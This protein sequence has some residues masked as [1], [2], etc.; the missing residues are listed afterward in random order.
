IITGELAERARLINELIR[1]DALISIHINAAPWPKGERRKLV[2]SDHAHVL[3]FGCMSAWEL[4]QSRQQ[5]ELIRKMI[6]GSGDIEVLLGKS[7]GHALAKGTGLV[8]SK[9][10]GDNAVLLDRQH[11]YL[12]ARNLMLLRLAECPVVMLEPYIANSVTSYP[13]IQE[14]LRA[15]NF[16]EPLPENDILLEYTSA[17]VA[18][19]LDAYSS[20]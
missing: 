4:A 15:R 6:N 8:A 18:G 13:R 3:I 14:A 17:V 11:P 9:Y 16:H 10:S 1:P 7:L 2:D 19:I 5:G 12:W 20:Q